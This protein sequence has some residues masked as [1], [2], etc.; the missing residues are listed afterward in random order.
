MTG[1]TRNRSVTRLRSALASALAA[2]LVLS[3]SPALAQ[4]GAEYLLEP[5]ENVNWLLEWN[6]QKRSDENYSVVSGGFEGAGLRVTTEAR[7]H[8]GIATRWRFNANGFTE[9]TEAYFRYYLYLEPGWSQTSGG[10]LPGF[11]GVY[12]YTGQGGYPSTP[13]SPG[14]SA[15]VKFTRGTQPDRSRIGYYIYH[16][17]Q[18]TRFGVSYYS[19]TQQ[20]FHGRWY[21]MEGRT[22]L[23]TPGQRDGLVQMWIDGRRVLEV[24]GLAFRR[25]TEPNIKIRE[26]ILQQYWGGS[27]TS[28]DV[29]SS[30][31]IDG[32]AVSDGRIGCG[33]DTDPRFAFIDSGESASPAVELR[34]CPGGSCARVFSGTRTEGYELGV[35]VNALRSVPVTGD[36]DGDG[37][38]EVAYRTACRESTCTRVATIG[39]TRSQTWLESDQFSPDTHVTLLAGDTL[40]TGMDQLMALV[41][42]EDDPSRTCLYRYRS[43]GDEFRSPRLIAR[44]PGSLSEAP[45]SAIALDADAD[46]KDEILYGAECRGGSWCIIRIGRFTGRGPLLVGPVTYLDGLPRLFAADADDDGQDDLI[47][48]HPCENWAACAAVFIA[49]EGRFSLAG[50]RQPLMGIVGDVEAAGDADGD[51]MADLLIVT[52]GCRPRSDCLQVMVGTGNSFDPAQPFKSIS[53]G[54]EPEVEHQPT[55]TFL[56]GVD[57]LVLRVLTALGFA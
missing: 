17:D 56:D 27:T 43:V 53:P 46:G 38:D 35:G 33:Q 41:V 55:N 32:V 21:C 7:H 10:K 26:F 24:D 52:P 37:V 20:L 50:A 25:A 22:L 30:S 2:I 47:T 19:T 48:V 6:W 15:R 13:A 4:E 5:F 57:G 12:S 40:G 18:P 44:L 39:R 9:P 54:P 16:L 42:C 8:L 3:A 36:F 28:P 45:N 1:R 34:T 51:G 49:S 14:W 31:V 29:T 11:M 23:N